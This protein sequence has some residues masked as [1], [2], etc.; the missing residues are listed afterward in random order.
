MYVFLG[1]DAYAYISYLTT[2]IS[3]GSLYTSMNITININKS[4]MVIQDLNITGP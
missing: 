4:K 3:K 1:C 2:R